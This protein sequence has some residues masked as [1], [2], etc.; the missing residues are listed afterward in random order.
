MGDRLPMAAWLLL[1]SG[2]AS[3]QTLM[4]AQAIRAACAPTSESS[5]IDFQVVDQSGAVLPGVRVS[6][7]LAST[8]HGVAHSDAKGWVSMDA[9]TPG[10]YDARLELS[11]F[12][13]V[14]VEGIQVASKCQVKL[15]VAMKISAREEV[16]Q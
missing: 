1:G 12:R 3:S 16:V 6:L 7:K 9:P 4:A 13:S 15:L 8:P 5:K 10:R 2:C 14:K 11:G